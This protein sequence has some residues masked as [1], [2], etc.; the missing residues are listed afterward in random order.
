MRRLLAQISIDP[1]SNRT[2]A[3]EVFGNAREQR[4]LRQQPTDQQPMRML[5]LR[6][7]RPMHRAIRQRV[8]VKHNNLLEPVGQGP[9]CG[10]PGNAG[11]DDNG[12]LAN[13]STSRPSQLTPA[14]ELIHLEPPRLSLHGG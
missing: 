12:C 10:Q 11:A 7:R 13:R 2:G 14:S 3:G 1:H 6:R 5:G 4:I 9:G 8:T